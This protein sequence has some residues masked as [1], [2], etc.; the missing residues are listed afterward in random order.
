MLTCHYKK[1]SNFS[2]CQPTFSIVSL[3]KNAISLYSRGREG[4]SHSTVG[5]IVNYKLI[6]ELLKIYF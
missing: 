3:Y 1:K 4:G 2:K 5:K 6:G